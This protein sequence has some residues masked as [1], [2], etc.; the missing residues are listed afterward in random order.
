[1]YADDIE[2]L[3]NL[4]VALALGLLIGVERGWHLR[5]VPEGGRVA[6]MRTFGLIGLLGGLSALIGEQ[7]GGWFATGALV[8]VAAGL[9]LPHWQ[10]VKAERDVGM[11]TEVAALVTF[12]LGA[13]AVE[14]HLAI[15]AAVA[16]V[17]TLLLG[18]KPTLHRWLER[19]EE[20][21]LLAALQLLLI[22]VVVLPV[23]PDEG[24]GPYDALNPYQ[25]WWMVV[26]IAGLSFAGYV[27]VKIAGT[28]RGIVLTGIFGGLASS[29]AVTLT[30]SRFGQKHRDLHGPLATGVILS[31]TVMY[32]RMAVLVAVTAP[33]LLPQLIPP[34]G[35]MAIVGLVAGWLLLRR[36]NAAE[37]PEHELTNPFEFGM[38]LR[39]GAL[40][41]V[42]ILVSHA[43][44]D[45][46]GDAGLLVVAFVSG[47]ADVDAITLTVGKLAGAS[48]APAVALGA[49]LLA[50]VA[51]TLVKC[52]MVVG[53]AGGAMGRWVVAVVAAMLAAGALGLWL[54]HAFV[55]EWAMPR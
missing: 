27:A 51:N 14:G 29:T 15:A 34:L 50:A 28:Q 10:A 33:S 54:S 43:L 17:A 21:E 37:L 12:C 24:F 13:L 23:L 11:T 48:M 16:V 18:L 20:R 40:L 53:I 3:R 46:L 22:S 36:A 42:V 19:V 1:M 47:L 25:I 41:A 55:E 5:K 39:F 49:L 2:L 9:M 30:F 4:G 32:A 8:A 38:A 31:W 44:K 45:W 6:G 7:L 52:A 26:L 35:L